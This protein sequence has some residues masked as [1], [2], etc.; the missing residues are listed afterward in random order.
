MH[1]DPLTF[2]IEVVV[3]IDLFSLKM[4]IELEYFQSY[5]VNALDSTI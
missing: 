5:P 3:F 1:A 4:F 2:G